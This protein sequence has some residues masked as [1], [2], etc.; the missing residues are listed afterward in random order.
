MPNL[1]YLQLNTWLQQ[2]NICKVLSVGL[3]WHVGRGI[4]YWDANLLCWLKLSL[5][6]DLD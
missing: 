2:L 1:W 4:F 6:I 3:C 5:L